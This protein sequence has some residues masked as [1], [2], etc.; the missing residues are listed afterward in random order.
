MLSTPTSSSDLPATRKGIVR[1]AV[2]RLDT[3]LL[4]L[5]SGVLGTSEKQLARF[6]ATL[7]ELGPVFSQFG[8]YLGTRYDLFRPELCQAFLEA[9]T[10]S[11][12]D[13]EDLALAHIQEFPAATSNWLSKLRPEAERSDHLIHYY[14]WP[15]QPHLSLRLL[16]PAFLELWETDQHLLVRPATTAS[17]LWPQI[18]LKDVIVS[19][20]EG[21]EQ[22]MDLD[23]LGLSYSHFA[24][25]PRE[26][27]TF[28]S[29]EFFLPE[30][31]E[32]YCA[33]GILGVIEPASS[34]RANA[35]TSRAAFER[36]WEAE[37]SDSTRIDLARDICVLWL[38]YTLRGSWFPIDL[39]PENLGISTKGSPAI[40]GGPLAT[41]S[42]ESQEFLF[43][44]LCAT[45]ANQ[46]DVAADIL[47]SHL[48]P[49]RRAKSLEEVRDLFRQIVP[50]RD[51]QINKTGD[52][53]LFAEHVLVQLRV[54]REAGY[55]LDSELL[56]FLQSFATLA[57][58]VHALSPRRDTFKD[59]LYE[60]RWTD[61]L[62]NLRSLF[63]FST[64]ASQGQAWLNLMM[65]IPEKMNLAAQGRGIARPAPH[66]SAKE[67]SKIANSFFI[68]LSH[69]F[70]LL[71]LTWLVHSF[72][73]HEQGSAVI[74]SLLVVSII[75]VSISMI[76]SLL[77]RE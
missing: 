66:P 69:A 49:T 23:A 76:R 61:S 16:N 27:D 73:A 24:E 57:Q 45:A 74:L 5:Q 63:S 7:A 67:P 51:G 37:Q 13:A 77:A 10:V 21:T 48:R 70:V 42:N 3:E 52:H 58:T 33:P 15:G 6:I 71:V 68:L 38:R 20:R 8:R 65:E 25:L 43:R 55:S 30:T 47:V 50:F 34:P 53:E 4:S 31:A 75:G 60:F 72:L 11:L 1:E 26:R 14:R 2:I 44:Y 62:A 22:L 64:A 54:I 32:E 12:P 46:P 36:V 18:T 41:V 29:K 59:A 56:T 28:E 40:L 39:N 19:F 9:G 35:P 17:R